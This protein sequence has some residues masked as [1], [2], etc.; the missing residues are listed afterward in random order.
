MAVFGQCF[1]C[2]SGRLVEL[3]EEGRIIKGGEKIKR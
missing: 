3:V 2:F 1:L